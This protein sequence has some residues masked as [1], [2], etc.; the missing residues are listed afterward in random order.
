MTSIIPDGPLREAFGASARV[1]VLTG[2]G[3]SAESGIPTFRDALTGLWSNFDAES[4]ATPEAFRRDPAFVWGWYEWRRAQVARAQPNAG[5]LALARL[6]SMARD[7][8]VVTQNV[9]DLHERAGS[10]AV[11]HLHGSLFAPRCVDCSQPHRFGDDLPA[12]P[13]GGRRLTPPACAACGGMVRPGVVWFGEALPTAAWSRAIDAVEACDLLLVVGTSGLVQPAAR[14]PAVAREAGATVVAV[15]LQPSAID[16]VA[17]YVLRGE[18]GA[19]LPMLLGADDGA[20]VR[21][22]AKRL[23]EGWGSG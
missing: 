8:V 22:R 23:G 14:L 9:D 16:A 17:H 10:H 6:E 13:D 18:A 21:P 2:A 19:L 5:H 15:N 12:E 4:L 11:V 20:A 3:I 1:A 7:V